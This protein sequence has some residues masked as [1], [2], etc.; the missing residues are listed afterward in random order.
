[1]NR[2]NECKRRKHKRTKICFPAYK[3]LPLVDG[4]WSSRLN[5]DGEKKGMAFTPLAQT[6]HR[7]LFFDHIISHERTGVLVRVA[8]STNTERAKPI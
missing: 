5:R 8:D 2:Q 7:V 3:R 6:S 1:M 4:L